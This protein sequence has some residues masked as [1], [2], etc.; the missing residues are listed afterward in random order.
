MKKKHGTSLAYIRWFDSAISH[1]PCPPE[2]LSG[3]CE[4]ESAGL[5]VKEDAKEIIIA[6]DCCLDT[7][8]VRLVLCIPK[9]NVRS[10]RRFTVP[11]ARRS[12]WRRE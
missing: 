2:D 5:L 8:D 1:G 7:K 6:L 12:T 3:T 9:V 4:N 11:E 10:I